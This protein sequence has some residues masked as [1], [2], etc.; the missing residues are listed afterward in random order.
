MLAS[1]RKE[2]GFFFLT[3]LQRALETGDATVPGDGQG[4]PVLTSG[5]ERLDS[6]RQSGLASWRSFLLIWE[7][8][9]KTFSPPT[10]FPSFHF[11]PPPYIGKPKQHL[12]PYLA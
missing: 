12:S 7:T 4:Q 1:S 2:L 10:C 8:G 6:G 5:L 9:M 11:P 3:R